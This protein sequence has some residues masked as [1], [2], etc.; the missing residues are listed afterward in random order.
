MIVLAE[1]EV[2]AEIDIPI[3]EGPAQGKGDPGVGKEAE[4]ESVG[5]AAVAEVVVGIDLDI[6]TNVV[7]VQVMMGTG[8]IVQ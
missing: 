3:E 5:I 1:N 6:V 2:V 7:E 8:A 4:V